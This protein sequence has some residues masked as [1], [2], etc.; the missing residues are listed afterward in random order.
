MRHSHAVSDNPAYSDFERPLTKEGRSLASKTA[1]LLA[2]NT[3]HQVVCSSAARTV[4]TADIVAETCGLNAEVQQREDLY[5][6]SARTYLSVAAE[7]CQENDDSILLVGHN[8]GLATLICNW[9]ESSLSIPP[10]SVAIFHASIDDWQQ[11][12]TPNA[13]VVR[14]ADLISNGSRCL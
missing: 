1:T 3:I 14:L 13:I 6:A 10:S 12:H 2:D 9:A 11:L 4:E 8:P 5:L 7:V